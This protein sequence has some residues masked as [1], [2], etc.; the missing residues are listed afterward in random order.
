MGKQ[1][2]IY[3]GRDVN[4]PEFPH[5][6]FRGFRA[7]CRCLDCKRAKADYNLKQKGVLNPKF[8]KLLGM[9]ADHPDFPHGTTTGYRYC[10]CDACRKAHNEYVVP[11]N[12]ARMERSA[13]AR[14]NKKLSDLA[15]RLTDR[16]MLVRKVAHA[17]RKAI[18]KNASCQCAAVD[19]EIMRLIYK[20][21]PKGYHV[22]HIIPLSKGGLHIPSNLQYLP[23]VINMK[24]RDDETFDCS[25]YAIRWQDILI[26][27]PSTTIPKGST[28]KQGEVPHILKRDDDIVCSVGKL[29]A[30]L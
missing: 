16:G 25:K 27:E 17:K 7:G 18:T 12:R 15:Y 13:A 3:H 14:K 8:R 22:D 19:I 4:H 29:T 24:K 28:P 6:E 23:A 2:K 10:K 30:A 9:E 5:G 11:L 1:K 26:T 20:N 21:C